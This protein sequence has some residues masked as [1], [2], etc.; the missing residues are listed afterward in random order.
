MSEGKTVVS[1]EGDAVGSIDGSTVGSS[2]SE[3]TIV[4]A[5]DVKEVP[6]KGNMEMG[7]DVG[8]V[9]WKW[10]GLTPLM[11]AV[12][13]SAD[14]N[15]VICGVG[16]AVGSKVGNSVLFSSSYDVMM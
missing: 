1:N 15:L 3:E 7:Y 11:F 4:G 14:A 13:G 5:E 10:P 2:V 9:K 6:F 16:A 8:A 12:V